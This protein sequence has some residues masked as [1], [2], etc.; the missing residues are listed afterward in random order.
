MPFPEW[1]FTT[2]LRIIKR[3]RKS[4]DKKCFRQTDSNYYLLSLNCGLSQQLNCLRVKWWNQSGS[5]SKTYQMFFAITLQLNIEMSNLFHLTLVEI[6]ISMYYWFINSGKITPP[7]CNLYE[8]RFLN[9]INNLS[10]CATESVLVSK[11]HLIRSLSDMKFWHVEV[12]T[13]W[14]HNTLLD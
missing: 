10:F 6:H 14:V 8:K 2:F 3:G 11:L 1:N 5:Q 13:N 4:I 12:F 9:L 7:K